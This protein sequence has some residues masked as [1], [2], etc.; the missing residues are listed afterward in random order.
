MT[1][2]IDLVETPRVQIGWIYLTTLIEYLANNNSKIDIVYLF[3]SHELIITDES[4]LVTLKDLQIPF[5]E[6]RPGNSL[7]FVLK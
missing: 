3:E 2:S 1:T 5:K 7:R 4:L 6:S